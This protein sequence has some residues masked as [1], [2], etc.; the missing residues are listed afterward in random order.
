MTMTLR[1]VKDL[2]STLD[3]R[4]GQQEHVTTQLQ[5]L[6]LKK[7][8]LTGELII[9]DRAQHI[10]HEVAKE[11]QE[12]LQYHISD[13]VSYALSSVFDDPYAFAVEFISRRNKIEAD[14]FLVR[15]DEYLDP[16][17]ATG[18]GV[19][20]LVS[21]ALRLSMW[22]LARPSTRPVLILDEP[23]KW[24]KGKEYPVRGAE[25]IQQFSR[26]LGVQII[27]NSHDPELVDCADKIITVNHNEE[28]SVI[29]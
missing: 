8:K 14:M 3:R 7:R 12:E 4:K 18:G 25:M 16:L 6:R 28:Y 5:S 13:I 20:D 27:M 26:K 19:V 1:A 11:T 17:S 2:R 10:I 9:T 21:M 22:T 23:M 24:L 29:S 15:D